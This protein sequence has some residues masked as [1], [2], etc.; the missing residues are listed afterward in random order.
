MSAGRTL[1]A[2]VA[3]L[4]LMAASLAGFAVVGAPDAAT[5][6][7]PSAAAADIPPEYLKL[8]RAASANYK[9]GADG[10]SYLAG[11]GKIECDHGRLTATGCH[12][13]EQN[14]AGAA[15]PAQFLAGTW[16]A[17]G[18]DADGDGRKDIYAPADA[19]FGMANYLRASG[20][21]GDWRRALFA[22]NHS[23]QYVSDVIAQAE[24]YRSASTTT[25]PA[26]DQVTTSPAGGWL[27]PI[28]GWPGEQCDARIV[29]DVV[30]I[31]RRWGLHVIDCYGGPP[32]EPAGEH[33]LGLA[34]DASPADGD[35]DRTM[36]LARAAGWSPSCAA[37]GCPGRGPFRVVLY[38]GYPDH[39]DP[40]HTSKPH[41]HLSWQ[42]GPAAPFSRAPWVRPLLRP[43]QSTPGRCRK[44]NRPK[45][46]R[47][48]GAG[49]ECRG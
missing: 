17:Y 38:N 1:L 39:G 30:A 26:P 35:W 7:S 33:P 49:G 44:P 25:A 11:V 47:R 10:W 9:L 31:V 48:R 5:E 37:S 23:Q 40:A 15:G 43:S 18:V 20:A 3:V 41:I 28:P 42:H 13:G 2:G 21:P 27:A 34:L 45:R 29:P 4:P 24:R 19:V 22:Y 14:F 12:R 32:H 8:Y 16:A 36:G 6:T 46:P